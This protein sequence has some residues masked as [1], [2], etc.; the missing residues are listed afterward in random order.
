[1]KIKNLL[2][3]AL[4]VFGHLTLQAQDD[5]KLIVGTYTNGTSKGIYSFNFNQSTGKATP[6]DTLELKNP[7]FLTL[8]S[9]GTMIYAVN[10]NHDESAAVNAITFDKTTGQM[11]LQSSFPTKG[12]DPCYVETNGNLLLTANY[13]GGSMSVFPLNVDGSL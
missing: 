12:A 2:L 8:A 10:E 6:L 7:S 13:S 4:T 3:L 1:M 5:I 11:Q 9:D